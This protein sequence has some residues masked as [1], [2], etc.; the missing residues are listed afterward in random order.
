MFFFSLKVGGIRDKVKCTIDRGEGVWFDSTGTAKA[1]KYS[2]VRRQ[3]GVRVVPR[4]ESVVYCG[5]SLA[6]G[7]CFGLNSGDVVWTG[8]K[9]GVH[10]PC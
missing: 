2:V 5:A 7:R 8:E 9:K 3:Q 1:A 10:A 6:S 4:H